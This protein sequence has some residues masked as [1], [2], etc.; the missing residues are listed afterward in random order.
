[1]AYDPLLLLFLL[2][3]HLFESRETA[4]QLLVHHVLELRQAQL[5]ALLL[6]DLLVPSEQLR[7]ML[8]R[9]DPPGRMPPHRCVVGAVQG[10]PQELLLQETSYRT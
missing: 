3:L 9:E 5:A 1:M 8:G 7:G 2:P 10:V 6:A 4:L